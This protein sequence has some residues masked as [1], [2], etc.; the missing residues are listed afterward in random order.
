V[1]AEA[2]L[3]AGWTAAFTHRLSVAAGKPE[4]D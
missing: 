2:D 1:A 4:I 3:A